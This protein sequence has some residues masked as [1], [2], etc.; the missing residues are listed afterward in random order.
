[1]KHILRDVDYDHGIKY[2]L[3][4]GMVSKIIIIN[5][6]IFWYLNRKYFNISSETQR[7][8]NVESVLTRTS[9]LV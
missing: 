2:K 4:D 8:K 5:V 6:I 3:R 1:M 7:F 9:N